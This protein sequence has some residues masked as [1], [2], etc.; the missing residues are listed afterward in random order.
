MKIALPDGHLPAGGLY[1][2]FSCTNIPYPVKTERDYRKWRLDFEYPTENERVKSWTALF[3]PHNIPSLLKRGYVDI[4]ISGL[5]F[6]MDRLEMPFIMNGYDMEG[7]MKKF[8]DNLYKI[9]LIHLMDLEV[10]PSYL[11]VAVP[12]RTGNGIPSEGLHK[13]ID[14]ESMKTVSDAA[15]EFNRVGGMVIATEFPFITATVSRE[16]GIKIRRGGIIVTDG[17]TESFPATGISHASLDTTETKKTLDY[18][19]LKNLTPRILRS[20]PQL[21]VTK[22]FQQ[23]NKGVVERLLEDLGHGLDHIHNYHLELILD[24]A[25]IK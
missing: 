10:R 3:R 21:V 4:G 23:N 24:K 15:K 14:Y 6:F 2:L 11:V 7:I 5:D 16:A 9:D 8:K 22:D 19:T 13:G 12:K 1:E 17:S 20:T 25:E 18:N